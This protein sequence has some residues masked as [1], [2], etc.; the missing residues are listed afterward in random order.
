V[1]S[2]W[3]R[4]TIGVVV[5]IRRRFVTVW[6][7]GVQVGKGRDSVGVGCRRIDLRLV[8]CSDTGRSRV[9]FGASIETSAAR[10]IHWQ[11]VSIRTTVSVQFWPLDGF[12]YQ[13]ISYGFRKKRPFFSLSSKSWNRFL[14]NFHMAKATIPNT[15]T[16]P[17]T[18][19]PI[20][21][22][23]PIPEP[24]EV[25]VLVAAAALAEELDCETVTTSV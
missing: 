4:T 19:R 20:I 22:P 24:E 10:V 23:V 14:V 13:R 8:P 12:V 16:P 21:E 18:D 15:A 25:L 7:V 5:R 3:H 9:G 2:V 6:L 17:A 1:K 11:R